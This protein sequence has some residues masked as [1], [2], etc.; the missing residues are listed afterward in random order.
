M[1]STPSLYN[2]ASRAVFGLRL[3]IAL[4]VMLTTACAFS[5]TVSTIAVPSPGMKK[6]VP[7]TVILPNSYQKDDIRL[8]VLYLL[9][10]YSDNHQ[11]WVSRTPVKEL[12]DQYGIIVVCPDAAYSSW[13]FDSPED[14]AWRYETFVSKELVTEI[15]KRY[16]TLPKRESRA[17]AGQSMGG[18]GALFLAIR[19]RETFSVAVCLSG[20]VDLRPFP[21]NWDIAKR[22][23]TLKEHP[24][25]WAAN[26]V[27]TLAETLPPS[28]LAISIDCG[29]DDFF[30]T[31]NRNLHQLLVTRKVPHDYTERPG[32]HGWEY[33]ANAIKYQ[34]LFISNH[35]AR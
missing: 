3:T 23:G 32:S 6:D 28:E 34:M 35:L 18:H 2:K 24:D 16:R 5:A 7:A 19:H 11:T 22:L 1:Y 10:G 26:S 31:V 13:Y 29:A 4:A 30:I 8:P 14:P 27:I 12:A 15:D 21:D 25:R 33:W 9:H 20:G 17:I